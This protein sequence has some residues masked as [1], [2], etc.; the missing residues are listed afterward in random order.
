MRLHRMSGTPR[1][2]SHT[3]SAYDRTV[4]IAGG[5]I[6]HVRS[7]SPWF[8][9]SDA[10]VEDGA[11]SRDANRT[12]LFYGTRGAN[13]MFYSARWPVSIIASCRLPT[14]RPRFGRPGRQAD[15]RDHQ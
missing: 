5:T 12:A 11:V 9:R 1:G 3:Q 10:F 7:K 13:R 6:P 14:V 2:S 8:S 15:T 4:R